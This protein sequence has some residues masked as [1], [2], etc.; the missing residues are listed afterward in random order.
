MSSNSPS[1]SKNT[2]FGE[3]VCLQ[4]GGEKAN[5]FNQQPF[6]LIENLVAL[7]Q[8]HIKVNKNSS[9]GLQETATRHGC[10]KI[11]MPS[12]FSTSII[13]SMLIRMLNWPWLGHKPSSA[14]K[15]TLPPTCLHLWRNTHTREGKQRNSDL[16]WNSQPENWGNSWLGS[17]GWCVSPSSDNNEWGDIG[18][19][20]SPL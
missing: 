11:F 19:V 17:R 20:V 6:V 16:G 15:T 10:I 12:D 13:Y 8:Q 9:A 3:W 14:C 4:H 7:R 1:W 18:E 2:C 5:R